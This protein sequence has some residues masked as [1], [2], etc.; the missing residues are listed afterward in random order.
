MIFDI[1]HQ[2]K[3][4]L[5]SID[6]LD[7]QH[8]IHNYLHEKTIH[9]FSD[10][11]PIISSF[12][13]SF[14]LSESLEERKSILFNVNKNN[15]IIPIDYKIIQY[16]ENNHHSL[17]ITIIECMINEYI[18]TSLNFLHVSKKE[19][20]KKDALFSLEFYIHQPKSFVINNILEKNSVYWNH[21]CLSLF[22]LHLL[23]NLH[24]INENEFIIRFMELLLQNI[25]PDS[26]KM[27]SIEKTYELFETMIHKINFS[28][29]L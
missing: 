7:K 11:N 17:T 27:N 28:Y 15:K 26:S 22:F 10:K 24:T 29:L 21:Y 18:E 3:Y 19:L 20:W 4:L 6:L 5:K 23:N 8:I 25:Q 2:Y 16:F 12:E 14:A 13:H 9:L 1:I